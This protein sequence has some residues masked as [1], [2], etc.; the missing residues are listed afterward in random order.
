[1]YKMNMNMSGRG[2]VLVKFHGILVS[3]HKTSLICI[4]LIFDLH[5]PYYSEI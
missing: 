4:R 1:M 2:K 5:E 3:K